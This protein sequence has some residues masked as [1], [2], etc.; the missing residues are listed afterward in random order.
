MGVLA[1]KVYDEFIFFVSW[2]VNYLFYY[3]LPVL[4]TKDILLL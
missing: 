1:E 3:D 2:F 4:A